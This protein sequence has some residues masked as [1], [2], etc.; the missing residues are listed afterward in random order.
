[1]ATTFLIF[2]DAH[3]GL[4]RVNPTHIITYRDMGLFTQ[5]TTVDGEVITV[6]HTTEEVDKAMLETYYFVKDCS[7][8]S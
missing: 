7:N 8:V 3:G 5:M 6:E 4:L 1:M 2:K